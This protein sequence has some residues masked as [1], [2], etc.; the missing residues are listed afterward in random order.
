[1]GKLIRGVT[2]SSRFFCIDAK[3]IVQEAQDIH[4][5]S[6][7]AIAAFGRLLIGGAL[8]S[9]DLKGDKS[10]LTLRTDSDGILKN[11][12]VTGDGK[13][14][15]KGY[16]SNPFADKEE[17]AQ[18]K[19]DVRGIIGK[20]YLRLIKDMGLKEPYVG[21]S[22]LYT[23]EIG[24]D[25][26]YY[27]YTSEQIPS[28]VALGVSVNKDLSIKQAGG[29]IIQLMPDADE[30]F[31]TKLEEKIKAIR[32][33][34]DLLDGGMD[35][36]QIIKLIYED[37]DNPDEFIEEYKLLDSKDVKYSCDCN[38]DKFYKGLIT[39]GKDDLSNSFDEEGSIETECHFCKKKYKFIK[40]DFKEILGE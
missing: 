16:L 39:L 38:S 40:E 33:V 21:V 9:S 32:S 14:N 35:V 13:G 27:Y 6:A 31:I 29:Y 8:M 15:I 7:T 30:E 17:N 11:M 4:K 26:A 12:V 23:S 5:C 28:V 37:M 18:G 2:E 24:D 3:D 36:S 25:I 20:G 19:L 22:E 10:L 34:T 1:M